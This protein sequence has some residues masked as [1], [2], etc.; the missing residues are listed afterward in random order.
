MRA[1]GFEMLR[2]Q[3]IVLLALGSACLIGSGCAREPNPEWEF[4]T[5][6]QDWQKAW[7]DE[8]DEEAKQYYDL[9]VS[10]VREHCGT[11]SNPKMLG[12]P[13]FDHDELLKG[14]EVYITYCQQCHGVTGD[15]KGPAAEILRPRPRDYRQGDFKFTSTPFGNK[16]RREDLEQT[17]RQ[18]ISGTAMPSFALLSDDDLNAV[19]DYVLVLTHR[20]ELEIALEQEAEFVLEE[21]GDDEEET[22]ELQNEY[23][24]DLIDNVLKKWENAEGATVYPLTPQPRFTAD[25]VQRGYEAF[26][27]VGCIKCH[28]VDGRGATEGEIRK[29]G[30]GFVT[31]AADITSGMLH[32]GDDP[33][34]IYRRIHSGINGTPMP[35]FAS[36]LSANPD[37][38]WDLTAY[39][40]YLANARREGRVVDPIEMPKPGESVLE[41]TMELSEKELESE[42]QPELEN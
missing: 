2:E 26:L 10:V 30:W 42:T 5:Q 16:P 11:W 40:M 21:E 13:D 3:M 27:K 20:G 4:G 23:I 34:D 28:G 31:K 8:E 15:G 25:N 41:A 9:T 1:V 36:S 38:L 33:I 17:L 24:A 29:D 18:G 39:V 7:V 14:R 22:K 37:T 35:S 32:G 12:D 19:I 6:V